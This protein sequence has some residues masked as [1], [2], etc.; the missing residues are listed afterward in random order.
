VTPNWQ[1]SFYTGP[2]SDAGVPIGP[3]SSLT[4][5][6]VW[7]AVRAISESLASL[8]LPVFRRLPDGGKERDRMHP[9]YPLLNLEFSPSVLSLNGREALLAHCLTWGNG[10][11]QIARDGTGTA[12]KLWVISPSRVTAVKV[13]T[14]EVA[15]DIKA[16]DGKVTQL[17]AANMLHVAGLGFDGITGYSPASMHR[18]TFGHGVAVRKFGS[19]FFKNGARAAGILQHPDAMSQEAQDRLK[20]SVT[21]AQ[22]GDSAHSTMVLEEGITWNQI[23]VPPEEAQFLESQRFSVTDVARIYRIPPHMIGDLEHATFS[24]IEQQA[25]EFVKFT[26]APWAKRLEGELNRKL[27]TEVERRT[28]VIEH[29]LEGLL[30]GDILTRYT[31]YNM[32][33]NGGWLS[34]NEIRRLEN[35]N[36]LPGDDGNTYLVP[37]N[38]APADRLNELIDAEIA[39]QAATPARSIEGHRAI[40]AEQCHRVTRRRD[41]LVDQAAGDAVELDAALTISRALACKVLATTITAAASALGDAVDGEAWVYEFYTRHMSDEFNAANMA[42]A[43]C[44]ELTRS[45]SDE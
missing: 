11:A 21:A 13:G 43:I 16:D 30:R 33:R 23:S 34:S 4:L 19:T 2:V 9:L 35:M 28:H 7:A 31:A 10:Y 20:K 37:R 5:A 38:M 3:Q 36:P 44:R 8:P 22:S 18:N 26:I 45:N 6:A 42:D 1:P 27:L 39:P 14:D 41:S 25:L 40:I 17:P 32:G 29:N 15:Y 12:R 24:N